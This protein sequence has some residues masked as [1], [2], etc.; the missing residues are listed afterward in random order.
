MRG[1]GLLVMGGA[2][3]VSG[4]PWPPATAPRANNCQVTRNV[5]SGRLRA[6]LLTTNCTS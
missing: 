1:V 3:I 5:S 2:A 6:V 4:W